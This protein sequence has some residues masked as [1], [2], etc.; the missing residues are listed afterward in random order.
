VRVVTAILLAVLIGLTGCGSNNAGNGAD[1]LSAWSDMPA[2]KSITEFVDRVTTANTPDFVAEDDRIAVFDN[3]GTLW[4]EAPVPFQVAY[5]LDEVKRR[6]VGEPEVAADPMVQAALRGDFAALLA[7][8]RHDGLLQIM[9]LSHLGM[10]TDEFDTRVSDWLATTR[11]PRFNRPYDQ[12]TYEPQQQLLNYLRANG[13]R[14][15]IVSGGGT[16][17]MRVFAERV[18]RIPPEQVVG[19]T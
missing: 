1:P 18:Y 10:T 12:L 13:F 2:K 14:T 5:A 9:A 16:D 15:Y 7:G 17:F 6:A 3:D 11:H 4:A 19:S 8:D